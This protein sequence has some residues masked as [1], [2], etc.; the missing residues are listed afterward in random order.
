MKYLG[1]V[2]QTAARHPSG[3]SSDVGLPYMKPEVT[4]RWER[5]FVPPMFNPS[6]A[7]RRLQEPERPSKD[8]W[9]K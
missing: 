9:I 2:Q 4:R 6:A 7:N 8:L 5:S 1:K 3:V